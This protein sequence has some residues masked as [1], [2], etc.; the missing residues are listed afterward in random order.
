MTQLFTNNATSKLA[1]DI[2]AAATSLT[3]QAGDGAKFPN[4]GAGDDF[5]LTLFQLFGTAE[6]NHEILLV[7]AR[8]GDVL[9]VV[10]AQEGT[11]AKAFNTGDPAELRLTAGAVLPARA[12]ALTGALNEAQTVTLASTASML[13]GSAKANTIIISGSTTINAFDTAPIGAI[14]RTRFQ[15]ALTLTHNVIANTI[16]GGASMITAAGDWC[17][18]I[19]IGAGKWEMMNYT[20]ASGNAL[21]VVSLDKGGT[22]ATTAAAARA[23]LGAAP[24]VS[25]TLTDN[26]TVSGN[27]EVGATWASGAGGKY[28]RLF[29]RASDDTF[30]LYL[31]DGSGGTTRLRFVGR[32]G[33]MLLS[34]GGGNVVVG[35]SAEFSGEKLQV[36]GAVKATGGFVGDLTGNVAGNVSGNVIGNVTGNVTGSAGSAGKLQT[37]RKINGVAFDGTADITVADSSKLALT[38]HVGLLN[39]GMS[40]GISGSDLNNLTATGFYRGNPLTNAPDTG[41]WYVMVEGHDNTGAAAGWAK[42]TVT[43]YGSGNSYPAGATFV[44]V[45]TSDSWSLWRRVGL[46]GGDPAV[47]FAASNVT[48]SGSVIASGAG[49]FMSSTYVANGRNPIWR[50]G[51]AQGYGLSYFQQNA[52]INNLDTIGLH[53]GAPTAG[54]SAFQFVS[55]GTSF[56]GNRVTSYAGGFR[57]QGGGDLAFQPAAGSNDNGDIVWIN[58][59]GSERHRLWTEIGTNTMLYRYNGGTAYSLW[60]SGNMNPSESADPSS[61][62]RRTTNGYINGNYIYMTDDGNPGGNGNAVT[63]IITKKGD[64]YYR[65]SNAASVKAFLKYSGADVF[66]DRM[67]WTKDIWISRHLRWQNYGNGHI[68]FD[69]SSGAAP[70]GKAIDRVNS[71]VPWSSTYPTLMGWNGN[72]TYG[73]RVDSARVADNVSW[74]GISGKPIFMVDQGSAAIGNTDSLTAPGYYNLTTSGDSLCMLVLAPGGSTNITQIQFHYNGWMKFRNKTDGANW[75]GWK[76]VLTNVNI[77]NYRAASAGSADISGTTSRVRLVQGQDAA[78]HWEGQPGQPAWLW[79]G[80]EPTNMY[81]YDP[82]NFSVG[83]ATTANQL[84]GPAHTNGSDGWWR[85]SGNTGWYN[86]TYAVGIFAE[87][88]N[89][90]KVYNGASFQTE[91]N[92]YANRFLGNA[93]SAAAPTYGFNNDGDSGMYSGGD[94]TLYF[95]VNSSYVGGWA[96]NNFTSTGNIT[97]FSDER[98]K[99][100]WRPVQDDFVAKLAQVKAGVYDRTDIDLTQAG[101]GAQSWRELLPETVTEDKDG[102]LGV[103]YG[104]AALVSSVE[105]AKKVVQLENSLAQAMELIALLKQKVD[106][107]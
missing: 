29:Y 107:Q 57:A 97:A 15:G 94:G 30:G 27:A 16:L 21:G 56:F 18:W 22:G 95:C 53:F 103:N 83:Y 77:G 1:A 100:N 70:E 69:A 13:I 34:E 64:D 50:F 63:S 75:T 20:R 79:G 28:T 8:A 55:D 61:I 6:I 32:T 46:A 54:G 105:L 78:F 17:E 86:E 2:T 23:A 25:P 102:N 14:R 66:T 19:S 74:G 87:S 59:D 88:A 43:S 12:G 93:G 76:D 84:S 101:V 68:I 35:A 104:Q 98:L 5:L 58:G 10:R 81:V 80:S 91:G 72:E 62:V 85:S 39:S 89:L 82:R 48:A 73:V 40:L 41:W 90:V 49:G 67:D 96:G 9:T 106:L 51:S 45:K 99:T 47:E 65:S 31:F 11:T 60:H 52:G 33:A 36:A 3:L 24:L 71:S 38:G 37:A 4:P 92:S 7:T 26:V 42:Q 44:R